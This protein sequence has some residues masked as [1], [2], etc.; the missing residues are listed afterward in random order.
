MIVVTVVTEVTVVTN[1]TVLTVVVVVTVVTAVTLVTKKLFSSFSSFSKEIIF[2]SQFF[3]YTYKKISP[4]N[5]QIVMKLNNSI[6]DETLN[7]NLD[8]TQKFKLL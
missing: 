5:T 2:F 3:M 8:Q 1:V 6:C 7:S 4:K